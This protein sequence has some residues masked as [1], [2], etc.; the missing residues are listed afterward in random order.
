MSGRLT[1]TCGPMFAGKSTAL[2]SDIELF[3]SPYRVFKPELDTRS[4]GRIVLHNGSYIGA[5]EIDATDGSLCAHLDEGVRTIFIDEIQFFGPWITR[6]IIY[7]ILERNIDV[8]VYGLDLDYKGGAWPRMSE[9]LPL[10]D[11]VHKLKAVCQVCGKFASKT[12]RI[13]QDNFQNQ[14]LIGAADL[15]EP[16]CNLDFTEHFKDDTLDS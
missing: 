9:L 10:A 15:Y 6:E 7:L 5:I 13:S 14:V 8:H 3:A 11:E 16:R 1:V 12:V 2:Q 4:P